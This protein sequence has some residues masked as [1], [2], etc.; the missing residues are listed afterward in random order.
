MRPDRI[1]VGECRGGEALDMIQ[2]M[3]TGHAGSMTTRPRQQ[4]R[5]SDR[6]VGGVGADGD[7]L[8]RLFDP[9]AIDLGAWT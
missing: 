6:A 8:A 4:R 3:N 9:S 2:A 5:G 1:I 7:R